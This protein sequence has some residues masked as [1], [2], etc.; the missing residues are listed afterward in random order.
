MTAATVERF[1]PDVSNEKLFE[2]LDRDGCAIVE[3]ALSSEQLAG[4]NADL[5]ELIAATPPGTPT[6]LDFIQDFYGF[7]T[8]RIDGLPGKS[9]TYVD[10]LQNPRLLAVADHFLQPH[11][12][13]YLLNTAQ[14]IQIGPGESDQTLHCDDHAF[15]HHPKHAAEPGTQPQIEVEAMYALSDFTRE[16]GATRVVPG[17][18]LWPNDRVAEEHEI[19]PAEMPAGS[20][21]YYLGATMH[22]GGAN[23]TRDTPR[24]GLFTG[25]IVGWLRTEENFFLS[26]PIDAVR[27]MPERVQGLLG[28][29]AYLGIGVVDVGSPRA[30]L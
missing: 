6:A 30:R 22:G 5:E 3:G 28:Y 15:M 25:F 8:I 27:E 23:S 16:N 18:H 11:C 2:T 9:K 21:I 17:S 19:V 10:V 1:G 20:A 7:E 29:D 24:R 13:H 12:V 4:M 26:T 14:L